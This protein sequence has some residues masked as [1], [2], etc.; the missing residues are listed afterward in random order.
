MGVPDDRGGG[1]VVVVVVVGATF[2]AAT[3]AGAEDDLLDAGAEDRTEADAED[4]LPDGV[5]VF[6]ALA[7]ASVGVETARANATTAGTER[8]RWRWWRWWRWELLH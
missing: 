3:A 2:T 1:A 8:R 5:P 6:A 4:A 7:L